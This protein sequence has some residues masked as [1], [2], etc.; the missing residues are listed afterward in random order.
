MT[1]TS[2]DKG[3]ELDALAKLPATEQH[4]L[5]ERAK[6]GE[7]VSAKKIIRDARQRALG[8]RLDWLALAQPRAHHA[9]KG[10]RR[11]LKC[12]ADTPAKPAVIL[13]TL[14]R[15]VARPLSNMTPRDHCSPPAVPRSQQ[16]YP[17]VLIE[18]GGIRVRQSAC[19]P[20]AEQE[21]CSPLGG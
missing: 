12:V 13:G 10:V 3:E 21:S 15:N 17:T 6:N 18:S 7:K 20:S 9:V 19:A 1:G 14:V 4:E 16:N 5:A 8:R 2:L 11:L